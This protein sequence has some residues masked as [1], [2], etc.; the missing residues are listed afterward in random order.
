MSNN[1]QISPFIE[2]LLNGAIVQWVPLGEVIIIRTGQAVNRQLISDNPGDY[3]VINSGRDPLGYI[4][5]WNTENDPI[6]ITSRGAGVGS[7]TWQDGKYYRGNLNYSASI[8][9]KKQLDTR[10]LYH[11]LLHMQSE[12]HALC[13]FDGIPALNAGNLR[14]LKIPIPCPEN[15]EKSLE[16]QGEIARILDKFSQLTAELTAELTAR[17][18]QYD[19]FRN[20]LLSFPHP[21]NI[22]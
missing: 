1:S 22:A 9:D 17:K 21:Q 6:G 14:E 13:T 3:P 5:Q 4:D 10:Y 18:R 11:L 19:Y 2:R 16:I 15:P 12:I 7:I 8:R 20:L